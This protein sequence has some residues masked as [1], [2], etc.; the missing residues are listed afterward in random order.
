MNTYNFLKRKLS[1]AIIAIISV[2]FFSS[3]TINQL[4]LSPQ[5]YKSAVNRIDSTITLLSSD[6]Q[7]SGSGSERKNEIVV[8]GQS[9]SQ[10]SG[11][12]TL[13]DNEYYTYDN[14]IY[15]DSLGKAI[16]FQLKYKSA[17]DYFGNPYVS[18][19]EVIKCTCNDKKIYSSICGESGVVK[20][21]EQISPDQVSVFYDK[22]ASVLVGVLGSIGA[23]IL[24]A[25]LI[26]FL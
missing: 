9:Y 20:K 2:A 26:I 11:Y 15:T 12:G 14:Y 1:V 10:Y 24:V 13:M 21:V 19:I 8:T 16:E 7:L 18:N 25:L 6:Y 3:C 17:L 23:G 4:T 5:S 22:E